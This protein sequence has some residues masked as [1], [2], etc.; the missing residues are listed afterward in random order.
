[1]RKNFGQ[2]S[3]LY[4]MPVLIVAAYDESGRPNA[5]NAAWGGMFT[6]E[7]IGICMAEEHKTTQNILKTKAFTVSIGTVDTM[8][9]CDCVGMVSGNKEQDKFAIAGLHATHS[10]IVNAPII[11]EMPMTLECELLSY[12]PESCHLVGKIV[13]IS[14]DESVLTDGKI[15][16]A[17]LRPITYDPV[18]HD[19]IELGIRV[20]K[21]FSDGKRLLKK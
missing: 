10:E 15:D 8:V 12:D 11:D 19:Y 16:P 18:N 5:M 6:D 20:G 17:K 2:K 13:N 14:V 9:A 3:W 21:A 1:M 4:P 7:T